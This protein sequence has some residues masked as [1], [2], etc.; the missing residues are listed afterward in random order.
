MQRQIKV[1][2]VDDSAL[3]RSMVSRLLEE[4]G[5]INVVDTARDGEEGIEKI[6]RLKPDAV[7]MDVEMPCMDG[8]T[9]LRQLLKRYR[10]PVI[11][12]STLTSKGTRATMKALSA[13]A[14]D[15]VPKPSSPGEL[16]KVISQL[17]NKIT[18]TVQSSAVKKIRTKPKPVVLPAGQA[19]NSGT[20]GVDLVVIGSSTGG[21]SALHQ[22]LPMLPQD[23]SSAVVVVQHL[24]RGFSESMAEHL[25]R[26]CSLRVRHGVDNDPVEKSSILVAPAG[27]E[28]QFKKTASGVSIKL[29]DK[30]DVPPGP[31]EFRP[32]V[33]AAMM[34]A[35]KVYGSRAMGVLLT[36]M[37]KDGA[38]GM[39]DMKNAGAYTIAEDESTC[40][41]FGMPG[42][43]VE[44]GAVQNVLPL[45]E[46]GPE[47][48]QKV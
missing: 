10:V 39:L 31:G 2:V 28:L 41:V 11:M 40:V 47:I 5:K 43:A 14:V 22:L 35:A 19:K 25:D 9:A 36:G 13:G 46:I 23:F 48:M 17:V 38:R 45:Q 6:C 33:N 1:V 8:I 12:L 15:F 34:S 4:T 18:A 16:T 37:G 32:S 29:D 21:P 3:I 42:A 30:A 26:N 44:Y 20:G 24:P 27:Y 7:T